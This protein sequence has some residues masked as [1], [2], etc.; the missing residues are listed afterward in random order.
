[1]KMINFRVKDEN[2]Q[3]EVWWWKWQFY[4]KWGWEYIKQNW[5]G[6]YAY[7]KVRIK[8]ANYSKLKSFDGDKH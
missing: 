8:N 4:K 3:I 5:E 2:N 7:L 6:N 1:M